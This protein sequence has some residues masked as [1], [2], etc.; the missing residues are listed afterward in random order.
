MTALAGLIHT[1][2]PN[3]SAPLQDQ[4]RA[5]LG[6]C[7]G[8]I[9]IAPDVSV[10]LGYAGTPVLDLTADGIQPRTSNDGRMTAALDGYISN[11]LTLR[12][13]L[14]D[15]GTRFR[16]HGDAELVAEAAS[17]W[18]LNRLLQKI[19][20][21]FALAL[22]DQ[23]ARALHLVRD[24][25]GLRQVFVR[26]ESNHVAFA[27]DSAAFPGTAIN[28]EAARQYLQFGYVRSPLT[29]RQNVHAIPPGHR[30]MLQTKDNDLPDTEAYWS[31]ATALEENALRNQDAEIR[32]LQID[33]LRQNL[34]KEAIHMDVPFAFFND[35]NN[36]SYALGAMLERGS[37]KPFKTYPMAALN[38]A[39]LQTACD[40]LSHMPE[41]TANPLAP[42]WWTTFQKIK[43]QAPVVMAATDIVQIAPLNNDRSESLRDKLLSFF[44]EKIRRLK[45]RA[46]D[47]Y[48]SRHRQWADLGGEMPVWLE[49]RLDMS[50]AQRLAFFDF[51][52]RMVGERLP[53]MARVA[54]AASLE[55]RLP[56]ADARFL[57]VGWPRLS[58]TSVAP[59]AIWLRGPLRPRMQDFLTQNQLQ[60]LG[61]E[62]TQTLFEA[63]DR[64]LKGEDGASQALWTLMT[65]L[66]WS[67]KQLK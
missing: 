17:R 63:W 39:T 29:L 6:V 41:P 16:G 28:M 58:N 27:S 8:T 35:G 15:L 1:L 55:L 20:G 46:R 54:A 57:D 36:D 21:A 25:L 22:W 67:S 12:R 38:G 4:I 66:A 56:F 34:I 64:F 65:L 53:A 26:R 62:N 47:A 51:C 2:K 9:W 49:P 7:Q 59:F 3:E 23:E 52:D 18:G 24:R 10:A 37:D 60:R 45:D 44:P 31:P 5:L 42:A 33:R 48:L 13:E 11:A 40:G 14:E 43:D 19:A 61:L 30:L 50:N 32:M